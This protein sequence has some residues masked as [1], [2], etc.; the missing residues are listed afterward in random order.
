[1]WSIGEPG[2]EDWGGD[3]WEGRLLRHSDLTL[4]IV[5]IGS[6]Q[7][8]WR[9][10]SQVMLRCVGRHCDLEVVSPKGSGGRCLVPRVAV[11]RDDGTFN[12]CCPWKGGR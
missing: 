1:M 12:G 5:H 10:E 6:S 2:A 4:E 11:F 9:G 7:T 3:T 8:G